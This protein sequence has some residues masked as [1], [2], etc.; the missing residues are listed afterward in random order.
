MGFQ[1]LIHKVAET[2]RFGRHTESLIPPMLDEAIR[3]P[4][5]PFRFKV[6]LPKGAD[7]IILAS[8]DLHTWSPLAKGTSDNGTLDYIDSEAFKYSYRFYRVQAGKLASTNVLG[9]AS[10]TLPPGFSMIANPFDGPDN[11]ISALFKGWPDG[12]TFNK[13]DTRFFRLAENAIKFGKWSNTTEKLMPG[14]GG[15]FFNPTTDYKSASF[16]GEVQQGHLSIPIPAG[17]SIRSSIL[18]QPGSLE[19]LGFPIANG[20]VIHLFDR[21]RQKYLLY[22]FETGKW[23]EGTPVTSV[24]ESFWVAKTEPGNWNRSVAIESE[25]EPAPSGELGPVKGK[26]LFGLFSRRAAASGQ[27]SLSPQR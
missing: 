24:G 19:D 17:F 10:V 1:D 3:F 26:K 13:F 8:T 5:G 11:T 6:R 20:D 21:D 25:L 12:T 9:Y 15:I 2:G 27:A 18:P 16:V 4:Y 14:E 22:P 23:T 7:Y